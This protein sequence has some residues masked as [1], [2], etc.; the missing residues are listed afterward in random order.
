MTASV[1]CALEETF[2]PAHTGFE[3]TSSLSL[4]IDYRPMS[5]ALDTK[6]DGKLISGIDNLSIIVYHADGVFHSY[7]YYGNLTGQQDIDVNDEDRLIGAESSEALQT[8]E[9]RYQRTTINDISL[10][11]G[12]FRI[13]AV[14]NLDRKLTEDECKTEGALKSISLSWDYKL[15]SGSADPTPDATHHDVMFGF[16]TDTE[17]TNKEITD[18]APVIS[19]NKADKQLHAWV[20]RA[21]SKVTVSF[22][23]SDL[24]EDVWISFKSVQIKD[25]PRYCALGNDN[26]PASDSELIENG[27]TISYSNSDDISQWPYIAKGIPTFGSDHS[28]TADALY[29]FENMQGVDPDDRYNKFQLDEDG[30]GLVDGSDEKKDLKPYGTYI[31]VK[32]FYVNKGESPSQ[33]Y[34]T[35]RFM[36]GKNVSDDFNAERNMHYKVNMKFKGD[37]NNVD[38]HIDYVMDSPEISVATPLYISYLNTQTLEIPVAIRGGTVKE[39]SAKII[40]NNWCYRDW[41]TENPAVHSEESDFDYNGFLSFKKPSKN[42]DV[43]MTMEKRSAE[44]YQENTISINPDSGVPVENALETRFRIPVWTRALQLGWGYTGNNIWVHKERTAKIEFTAVIY[45]E[46]TQESNTVSQI[47]EIKQVK[48]LVNPTG[49]WRKNGSEKP[50]NIKLLS[51]S[52]EDTFYSIVSDG[53]WTASVISGKDWVKIAKTEAELSSAPL[54][55]VVTGYTGSEIDFF[56]KPVD[57]NASQTRCGVI[58]ILYHGN[59]CVHYIFVSQGSSPVTMTTLGTRWHMSN[60]Y[61]QGVECASPLGE[62]SMFRYLNYAAIL[63]ENCHQDHKGPFE[64]PET[65]ESVS[66]HYPFSLYDEGSTWDSYWP[67]TNDDTDNNDNAYESEYRLRI[68][69]QSDWDDIMNGKGVPASVEQYTAL[70]GLPRFYGVMYGE[71]SVAPKYSSTDA[72]QYLYDGDDKGMRGMFVWDRNNEGKGTGNGNHIFFPIGSTGHGHRKHYDDKK[73][74]G[75]KNIGVLRYA[76]TDVPLDPDRTST[77]NGVKYEKFNSKRAPL[78]N[79]YLSEGAIYWTRDW[80]TVTDASGNEITPSSNAY[81]INYD[82]YDF[83]EFSANAMYYGIRGPKVEYHNPGYGLQSSDA[84]LIRCV[85]N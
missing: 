31:E 75:Y 9:S 18:A 41:Y 57:G 48:R 62:G 70:E 84:C 20:R 28:E 35:Y 37:A 79:L 59:K 34:I 13:Y 72:Y 68:N 32:A 1:S 8:N 3:G 2:E 44:Y 71:D 26:T 7:Y 66:G 39:L 47:I 60:V 51:G 21:A 52:D 50:F 11:N 78:Y 67:L 29:F 27:E 85:D 17:V 22:D 54:E 5:S 45:H 65:Y 30:D 61:R 24:N 38:W 69:D 43:S 55:N 12:N 33:G 25:I 4:Q 10:V 77:V 53:A 15:P 82:T 63:P 58:E 6:S 74:G 73:T 49:I 14:A 64:V 36:L 42:N 80:T 19:I 46:D 56:Y 83:N 76:T 81:D 40:E 16:F 23:G